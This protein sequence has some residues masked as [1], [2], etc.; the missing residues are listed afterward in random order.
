MTTPHRIRSKR[1]LVRKLCLPLTGLLAMANLHANPIWVSP[2]GN[3]RNPGTEEKPF[4]TLERARDEVRAVRARSEEKEIRVNLKGGTYRL[5]RTLVFSM[6]DS[7]KDGRTVLQAAPGETPVISSAHPIS[8]WKKVET[9]PE[10]FPQAAQGKLWVAEVPEHPGKGGVWMFKTLYANDKRLSR[11]RGSGFA[12][13]RRVDTDGPGGGQFYANG[14]ELDFPEGALRNWPN[15]QDVE[16]HIIPS[17]MWIDNMLPLKS[18]DVTAKRAITT[19]PATYLMARVER[20]RKFYI[21]ET[22]WVENVPEALDQP[23]EW[24]LNTSERKL[25]FWPENDEQLKHVCA[26]TLTELVRV[27]G[28]IDH[29][30]PADE[31]VRNLSFKGLTFCEADRYTWTSETKGGG[32]DWE[33]YDADNALLRFRGAEGCVVDGCTFTRSG[34]TGLRM[35]L[36]AQ[37][38]VVQ[39][40]KFSD[41]GLTGVLLF[42]YGPGTKDANHHNRI[43]NNEITR[44]GQILW[45]GFGLLIMQ[46]GHNEILNNRIHDMPYDGL[47]VVGVR[48]REFD[49][50][51]LKDGITFWKNGH[52][53]SHDRREWQRIFRRK[54]IGS[55]ENY[56]E[57]F[58]FIHSRHNLIQDNEVH[59][60]VQWLGDGNCVYLTATGLDNTVRRNLMYN[61][62]YGGTF[63][64]DDDQYGTLI[65]ENI[66]L[67]AMGYTLKNI[68]TSINNIA[69]WPHGENFLN[70]AGGQN[71]FDGDLAKALNLSPKV[72]RNIV[73]G[74]NPTG[75]KPIRA[76][77]LRGVGRYCPIPS[78]SNLLY[79]P[80]PATR[81]ANEQAIAKLQKKGIDTGSI[82]ADPLFVDPEKLDFRLKPE[83]PALKLGFKE[84]DTSHIGLLEQS[85]FERLRKEGLPKSLGNW[86]YDN[87]EKLWIP[88]AADD[89][90]PRPPV[91]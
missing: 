48:A 89:L 73:V 7:A 11:A 76:E 3:D 40:S 55:P 37:K 79:S 74:T 90:P 85:A 2:E 65:T 59:N 46:S 27:E 66:N 18:V 72:E 81:Q 16:I 28:N 8:G 15:L 84:I 68:N 53:Q 62:G 6:E 83:S 71:K 12:P 86:I 34:E 52:Q 21:K 64:C 26:P 25:Y 49:T 91:K 1:V 24:V 10:G 32:H 67:G 41:L 23:G 17:C 63:R 57:C 47:G 61:V 44:C 54:E 4:A 51:K 43:V 42:G 30:G 45:H 39:N 80:D 69:Y 29:D 35:D 56:W 70:L 50:L 87:K 78:S 58:R 20:S 22:V 75:G 5:S 60:C 13:T 33:I 19:V 31:P 88:I 38:N 36:H 14:D 82:V 9:L 77:L